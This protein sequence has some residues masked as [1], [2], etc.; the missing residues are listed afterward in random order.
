MQTV[1]KIKGGT[2]GPLH[3]PR[4]V[5]SLDGIRYRVMFPTSCRYDIG[6]PDQWD[7]NKLFGIGFFPWHK[8]H[9]IRIGWRYN[10]SLK[11]IEILAYWRINGKFYFDSMGLI[12]INRSYV[13]E[14]LPSKGSRRKQ[15]SVLIRID[16]GQIPKYGVDVRTRTIYMKVRRWGYLL[17]PYFGGNQ[18]APHTMTIHME[19]L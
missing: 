8:R 9:S 13:M 16:G 10:T 11:M 6:E 1:Y 19:R 18:V 17:R 4:F 14:V 7:V 5:R 3:F 12:H 2:H 15:D